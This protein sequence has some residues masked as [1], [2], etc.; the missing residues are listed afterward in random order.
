MNTSGIIKLAKK[1]ENNN[2][3]EDYFPELAKNEIKEFNK[4]FPI[5]NLN[6]LTLKEYSLVFGENTFCI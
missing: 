5:N 1:Y 4:K 3:N 2:K 6:N